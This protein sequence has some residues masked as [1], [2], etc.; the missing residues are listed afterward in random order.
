[1]ER[2]QPII[3]LFAAADARDWAAVRACLA[4]H[5]RLDYTSMAG[6]EPATLTPEQ[7]TTA[8]AALLPG[9]DRTHH[10]LSDFTDGNPVTFHG[11]AD[12]WLHG[13]VWTVDGD[14]EASVEQ[15]DGAWKVTTLTLHLKSQSGNTAL[16]AA[17]AARVQNRTVV[18][19]FFVA[20]ETS[21]FAQLKEVFAENGRQ[22]NPYAPPGFPASFDGSEA[23]YR[24]YSGLTASFGKMEFPRKIYATEDPDF[25]FVQFRGKIEIKAG[26]T[27]ENDYLGTF[28]L[29][30]G[31]IV[32]Y[33]EY[34]N[35]VVMAK[36]FGIALT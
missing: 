22:L 11:H 28:R 21:R 23:I 12:H 13:D 18:D 4:P 30:N 15:I 16:P 29:S 10:Q 3:R 26:G 32:E 25:F 34:F 5:V 7:I 17:A 20:L 33:T 35:Q 2:T 31:R 1:M 19:G 14:Y 8:W 27:Y 9:F 24:Q 6:G 36:A